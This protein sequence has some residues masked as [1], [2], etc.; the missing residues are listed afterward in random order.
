MQRNGFWKTETALV[1]AS[2]DHLMGSASGLNFMLVLMVT[3]DDLKIFIHRLKYI[4][5]IKGTARIF[6]S[7]GYFLQHTHIKFKNS[8]LPSVQYY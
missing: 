1:N 2:N 8:F 5:D 7:T 4:A 6:L 3:P